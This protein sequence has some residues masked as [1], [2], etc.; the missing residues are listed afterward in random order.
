[1]G[2]VNVDDLESEEDL[3]MAKISKNQLVP[4]MQSQIDGYRKVSVMDS[5]IYNMKSEIVSMSK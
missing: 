2:S 1:M 3:E 4:E 5:E